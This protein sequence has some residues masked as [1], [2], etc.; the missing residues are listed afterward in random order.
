MF[1]G[2]AERDATPSSEVAV[3]LT[4]VHATL[5]SRR[6]QLVPSAKHNLGWQQSI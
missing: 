5:V 3:E 1:A 4:I 2:Y 6:A